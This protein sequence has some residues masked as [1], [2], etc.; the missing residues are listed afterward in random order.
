LVITDASNTSPIVITTAA[1]HGVVDVSYGTVAD[2]GGNTGANGSW[3]LAAASPTALTLRGSV[4][5][6]AFTVPG[7]LTI[8]GTFA[9]VAELRDVMDAGSQAELI[10][11]SS[12]DGS[13]YSSM[14][15]TLKRTNA[16]RL[17]VNLVPDD[18]THDAVDGL[19]A[20]YDSQDYRDILLVMP[21]PNA[22]TGRPAVHLY[23]FV[24]AHTMA[25]AVTAAVQTTFTL[26][27][28]GPMTWAGS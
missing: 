23:G 16:M 18:P 5:T 12:H 7:T 27:F 11:T 13:G 25:L 22:V 20:L 28:D 17:D 26:E 24:A 14:I 4:G 19:L 6:G 1:P 15:P 21:A 2:V 8:P 10:D 3:V 9:S